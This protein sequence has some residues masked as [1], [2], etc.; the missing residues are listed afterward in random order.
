MRPFLLAI[1]LASVLLFASGVAASTLRVAPISVALT[2]GASASFVRVWNDD[3]TTLRV[4]ARVFRSVEKNGKAV[5]EPTRDVVASPPMATLKPGTE[6]LI[7]I[8]RVSKKPI[9][10]KETYRLVIDQLP[11]ATQVKPGT[12]KILVRHAIPLSFE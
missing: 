10:H 2:G 12:V 8:V 6:N 5:L 11:D 7:R 4:Q 3:K 9:D 1:A